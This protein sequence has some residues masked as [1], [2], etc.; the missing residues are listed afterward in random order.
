MQFVTVIIVTELIT[1]Q[2]MPILTN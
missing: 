1:K 2:Q